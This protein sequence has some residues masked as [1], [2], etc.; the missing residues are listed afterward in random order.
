M[1]RDGT[2][3][4]LDSKLRFR[5]LPEHLYSYLFELKNPEEHIQE[6]FTCLLRNEIANFPN[7][8]EKSQLS[9]PKSEKDLESEIGSYAEIRRE[10]KLLNQSIED[11]SKK[12]IGQRYGVRFEA[13]DL[14]D[15][16]PPEELSQALNSMAQASAEAETQYARAE[17]DSRQKIAS[18]K[19]GV[20]IASARA[21]AAE[22]E[23]LEL[24]GA[25]EDLSRKGTLDSYVAR[26]RTEILSESK[27]TFMKR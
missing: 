18:A 21:A 13:V 5:L 14:T 6:L 24:A 23:I 1:A 25:L 20:E 27:M 4:R 11:F 12:R 8:V 19:K 9:S 16:L 26:R 2:I 10:R 22:T 7:S 15:I 3:L 17:A